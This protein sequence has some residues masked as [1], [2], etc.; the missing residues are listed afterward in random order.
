MR[1]TV[2]VAKTPINGST[3]FNHPH[4]SLDSNAVFGKHRNQISMTG[5]SSQR[6]TRAFRRTWFAFTLIELLVVIAIIAILAALLLP[7]L[8]RA[9]AKASQVRCLS[10]IKQ[11]GLGLMIYIGDNEDC[12]PGAASRNTFSYQPEDWIYWR[13]GPS[14]PP[15]TKSPIVAGTAVANSNLFRCPMDRDDSG[16]LA[17]N[18]DGQGP[19]LFSYTLT[20]IESGG[21]NHGMTT[22]RNKTSNAA[23]RFK[24]TRVRNPAA[25]IVVMEEQATK[26]PGEACDPNANVLNDGRYAPNASMTGDAPTI[27]H[28][29]KCDVG[30]VDGHVLAVKP[31][32]ARSITNCQADL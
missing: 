1:R 8:A 22:T 30:F 28:Q 10:N 16:R 15:V 11:L 14:Y 9:K 25:K 32:F 29:N 13:I 24:L 19:Y 27:R 3:V 21:I 17:E 12:F 26:K 18:S 5:S 6:C 23:Q 20:S 31:A 4:Y 2:L 7:A